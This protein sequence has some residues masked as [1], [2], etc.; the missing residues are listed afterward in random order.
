MQAAFYKAYTQTRSQFGDIGPEE[1]TAGT[2]KQHLS[3]L[4]CAKVDVD[5]MTKVYDTIEEGK[6]KDWIEDKIRDIVDKTIGAAVETA[7]KAA[8]A[9]IAKVKA[10]VDAALEK[11]LKPIGELYKTIMTKLG[12]LA[13]VVL[14][15]AI[16]KI[17]K[18]LLDSF[19]TSLVEP[20]VQSFNACY[21]AWND[22]MARTCSIDNARELSNTASSTWLMGT[23]WKYMWDF[24][25]S[26][27]TPTNADLTILNTQLEQMTS[28]LVINASATLEDTKDTPQQA[29][30]ATGVLLVNDC[31]KAAQ[32]FYLD[33]LYYL[34]YTPLKNHVVPH[35]KDGVDK[36]QEL[37]QADFKEFVDLTNIVDQF[38]QKQVREC[39]DKM[40]TPKIADA[41]HKIGATK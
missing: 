16:D 23:T 9:A 34:I 29:W 22:S 28:D 14:Q 3:A 1:R 31:K 17:A 35:I 32:K 7:W 4:V 10:K 11:I 30:V 40:G 8:E 2:E 24:S 20:T 13:N 41:V 12:E 37:I 25:R 38:I 15:Q 26:A 19:A 39:V 18:P 21:R 6:A 36:L 5:I 33:M 27:K